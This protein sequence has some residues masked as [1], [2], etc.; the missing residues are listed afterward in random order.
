MSAEFFRLIFKVILKPE[1]VVL[2]KRNKTIGHCL[3]SASCLFDVIF[4]A[5]R[6]I[7]KSRKSVLFCATCKTA[8]VLFYIAA[9]HTFVR[10]HL[11][12]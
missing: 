10:F 4:V 5:F 11:C 3:L 1:E 12:A 2:F 7:P 9:F 6:G 8:K